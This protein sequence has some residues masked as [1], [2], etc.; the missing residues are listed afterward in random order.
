MKII[1]LIIITSLLSLILFN[2]AEFFYFES[3]AE[4]TTLIPT[5]FINVDYNGTYIK[6]QDKD[7]TCYVF[8]G[9]YKGGISCIK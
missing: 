9:N 6:F 7:V 5:K 3:S 2:S 4:D 1:L 8:E